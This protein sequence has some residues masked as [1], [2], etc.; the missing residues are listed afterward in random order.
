MRE[1][2]DSM[3]SAMPAL[4]DGPSSG[5]ASGF[6][7]LLS[8]YSGRFTLPGFGYPVYVYTSR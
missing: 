2:A 3:S 6:A 7:T 8:P 5:R 4:R 1:M